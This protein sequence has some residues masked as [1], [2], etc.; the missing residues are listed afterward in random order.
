ME[1]SPV[2]VVIVGSGA[3]GSTIAA[4]LSASGKSVLIL[5]SGPAWG[6]EHLVSSQLWARRLRWGAP[7]VSSRGSDPIAHTLNAG[8]GTGGAALHHY[9]TWPRLKPEDFKMRELYGRGVDWPISYDDLRPYYDR[10][11]EDVGLSGDAEAE[12][13]RPKGAPY[14]MP[15]LERSRQAKSIARGFAALGKHVAPTPMAINS[16]P[17]KGR[18]ACIY[19]G[20]CDAGCPITALANPIVTY[21]D[22]AINHGARII[23]DARVTRLI[24]SRPDRIDAVEYRDAKGATVVQ[25]GR[26]IVLAASV[27]GNP[28]ILLNSAS[29]L[30]PQGVGNA[31]DLVGRHVM[32]HHQIIAIGMFGEET[33]PHLGVSGASLMSHD[34]YGKVSRPGLFGSAQWLLA[35]SIKP[36]DFAR[37]APRKLF[38]KV[39]ADHVARAARHGAMLA[40]MM[41]E[42]PLAGNRVTLSG[43][44]AGGARAPVLTHARPQ[45]TQA[46][47]EYFTGQG[48]A[49]LEAAGAS[50]V[51]AINTGG[52]HLMGGTPM[53]RDA[54]SSVTDSY[55]RVHRLAN[56]WMA[57]AGLFPTGGA[58]NPTFTLQALSL[59][60]ADHLIANWR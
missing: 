43:A 47:G 46:L 13:W 48:L 35:P 57:G 14:P 32:T 24:A 18:A 41:E 10:V 19:D 54:T 21:L 4:V 60:T 50:G 56:L 17:Y 34:D 53:G 45:E 55:G 1:A 29:D 38:G 25:R 26:H 59:R 49:L 31:A 27:V 2:D 30:H 39:L 37:A 8:R 5:E 3:A 28:A 52:A 12:I 20:W 58:V 51:Y 11:Q 42:L 40:C 22:Q 16:I 36:A 33:E 23:N 9:A 15:P 6:L 44:P 7:F